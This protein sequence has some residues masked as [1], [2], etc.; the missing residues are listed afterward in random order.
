MKLLVLSII[1]VVI[2]IGSYFLYQTNMSSDH[3]KPIRYVA[4]GD[5]YTIGQSVAKGQAWPDQL[6]DRLNKEGVSIELVANPSRTGWTTKQLIDNELSYV[7][8]EQADFVSLLIGVNDWVQGVSAEKFTENFSFILDE[9]Q[10][11]VGAPR[12]LVVTIP[13]F[14]VVPAAQYLTDG[15][16]I[17]KGLVQ[18]NA[19]I[20]REAQ[21]R[22]MAVV[23]IFNISQEA[24]EK[25]EFIS[26]DGLHPSGVQ[27]TEWV[28]RIYPSALN[29]VRND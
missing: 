15:R 13:D 23:D 16:D 19:I 25:P 4:L 21:S 1:V 10:T 22:G 3:K 28:K 5:S 11:Q 24:K 12:V 6:V 9:L 14:S 2:L 7:A 18:F 29:I 26:V 8:S 27:Y 17:S 20:K